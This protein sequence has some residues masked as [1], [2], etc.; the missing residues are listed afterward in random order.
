[1]ESKP[2]PST[3][4]GTPGLDVF[5]IAGRSISGFVRSFKTGDP[6]R[7]RQPFTSRLEE[8][9]CL[10]LE[11]HPHVR[12]Y[13]RG[14]A[15]PACATTYNLVTDLGTPYRI[16]YVFEGN[17]HEYLP[18]YVGTFCDG[19]LL[20]AEA[21]RESEK[22]KGKALVK[23]EAAR[24]LAQIKG[25]EYWLGTDIHLSERRHQNWLYLHARRQM[26][27]TFAEIADTL[28][29]AWPYGETCCV[30]ELV[31]RFGSHWSEAEVEAAVWKMAGDAAADGRLLVDLT[32]MELSR[33]SGLTLLVPGTPPLLPD[34]LPSELTPT[35]LIPMENASFASEAEGEDL[36][37]DPKSAIPGPTF[38]ASVLS[39]TEEQA[40]FHR[41]LAAVTAVLAGMGVSGAARSYGIAKSTLS[42]LVQRT[43]ELGQIACVP[44]ATYHRERALHP[45]LQQLIRKLY[46]QPSRPTVMAIFEDI[47]LKHLAEQLSEGE[48]HPV[49]TPSYHQVYELIKSIS[50]EPAVKEARSGQPHL[51]RAR[52]SAKSF[53]L[54]IPYPAHI[55]QVDEHTMDLLVVTPEGT[56]LTRR[57]HGAVLICVKTAAILG[58]VLALD[59][60]CEE[61]YMRLVKMTME[62]KE[63]WTTLYDCQHPWPCSGKP[64]VIFHDRGKIFTSERATQV[65]VD[66]LG[67]TTEQAPPYAP[68]AKG[69]VEALFT[70]VTR[71]LTHRLPGTTKANPADRGTYDSAAEA[72]KAGIT[73][74]MLEKWFIQAIVDAYMQEW[75]RERRGQRTSLWEESVQ[76]MGVSRYLGSPDDLKLLLM[77]A[78]NRKNTATGRY[79]IS[80]HRGLSFLGYRYVSP[81]LLD[82]LRG[83]EIDIY[84]D[85]RDISVIYLFEEGE[86]RG[87]AYCTELLGQ[88]LSI[89]EA[90]A[91]R[92]S[93]AEQAKKADTVSLEARQRIQQEAASGKKALALETK[94]LEKQRLL[95]QQCVDIHPEK[96]AA[97]LHILAH[98]Q[99]ETPLPTSSP[100]GLLPPAVPSDAVETDQIVHLQIRKRRSSDE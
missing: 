88:R 30:S 63:R 8:Q 93:D 57:V 9:L 46:L 38:D 86:L 78:V 42:R 41:N 35:E 11:Y 95:D 14:D 67:I 37:L 60:L 84:F 85:R 24:R 33:S 99:A 81:G 49:A 6:R 73:L 43:K 79:A 75:D 7:V 19:G 71:K 34:P 27:P 23:A 15:S 31:Q 28:L 94:R 82:R 92:K 22:S 44:Y 45:D 40:H 2:P 21:G 54:S 32:E 50:Q 48:G 26:F 64:A 56:V 39:T 68:S 3:R 62:P 97:T 61:D 4:P 69:T 91:R 76:K 47:Q 16:N 18:D 74:D 58:A 65:L 89:W 1:M 25:G 80:P 13:Q 20:I 53:V 83:R 90:Q 100:T 51:P 98:Q 10:F 87:E 52:M 29:Q 12:Y 96:V 66:R 17:P 36:T 59:N 72:E 70:W 77:K 55:C 5:K